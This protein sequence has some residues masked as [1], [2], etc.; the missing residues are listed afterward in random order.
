MIKIFKYFISRLLMIGAG[1]FLTISLYMFFGQK[2]F[3]YFPDNQDFD[4]C[5]GF[6]DSKKIR[7][8]GTGMYYLEAEESE[9]I[10]VYY[11][12]N[13]GSA[14]DRDFIK[15]RLKNQGFSLLFVEYVGYSADNRKPSK[16]LILQDAENVNKF[17]SSLTYKKT[18]LMATSLGTAVAAYHQTLQSPEKMILI[19]PFD[20]L[21]RVAKFHYPFLPINLLLREEY[22]TADYMKGYE[23]EIII[24]HGSKDEIIPIESAKRLYDLI[25]TNEK[26]FITIEE[27]THNTLLDWPEVLDL[28][29]DFLKSKN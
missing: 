14:C 27:A 7:V 23:G 9:R 19:T 12:G 4:S 2:S 5:P 6:A 17:I 21:S 20:K 8:N 11:H 28:A 10:L 29:I 16:D 13:A 3:I 1:T 15:D 26:K 25:P 22:N 18:V 24:I